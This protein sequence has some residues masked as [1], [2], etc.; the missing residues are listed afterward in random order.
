MTGYLWSIS[1]KKASLNEDITKIEIINNYNSDVDFKDRNTPAFYMCN[2][3]LSSECPNIVPSNEIVFEDNILNKLCAIKNNVY[4]PVPDHGDNNNLTLKHDWLRQTDQLRDYSQICTDGS[5]SGKGAGCAV[6]VP[7]MSVSC[8]F[9]L[10]GSL[11][12]FSIEMI[13]IY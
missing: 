1:L 8:S 12:I 2:N 9:Q 6:V 7:S 5:K 4:F 11:S 10:L 13:A 3:L